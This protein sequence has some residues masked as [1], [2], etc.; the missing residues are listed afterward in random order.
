[1][2]APCMATP[3]IRWRMVCRLPFERRSRLEPAI[4]RAA[5]RKPS[6]AC[7]NRSGS[8][9]HPPSRKVPA[10]FYAGRTNHGCLISPKP[11]CLSPVI[12]SRAAYFQ[13]AA[14]TAT[15]QIL[16][17]PSAGRQAASCALTL[18]QRTPQAR[19]MPGRTA[20]G[21]D[22]H[23]YDCPDLFL[24]HDHF[25]RRHWIVAWGSGGMAGGRRP[26]SGSR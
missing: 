6:C 14:W 26:A 24:S 2:A 18:R 21:L 4:C 25:R 7:A 9:R 17:R 1:V 15:S 20:A 11:P 3:A 19:P 16:C 10:S 22:K 13:D 23:C 12:R 5:A 8:R